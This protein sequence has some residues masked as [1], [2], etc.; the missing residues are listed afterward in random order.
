MCAVLRP[1][2]STISRAQ[3][4]LEEVQSCH[5]SVGISGERLTLYY[6]EVTDAQLRAGAGGGLQ[7]EGEMIDVIEMTAEEA[8]KMVEAKEVRT[9]TPTIYGIMWFLMNKV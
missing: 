3:D 1:L 2:H 6:A 7:E 9:C 8:R 5:L 4:S